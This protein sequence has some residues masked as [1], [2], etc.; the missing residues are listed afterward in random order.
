MVDNR[1]Q[2]DVPRSFL[3][4]PIGQSRVDVALQD[5]DEAGMSRTRQ[6]PMGW[7][8]LTALWIPELGLPILI[9]ALLPV[10]Y[11]LAPVFIWVGPIAGWIAAAMAVVALIVAVILHGWSLTGVTD[12][13]IPVSWA[14]REQVRSFARQVTTA[15][16][17]IHRPR[18]SPHW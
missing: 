13:P 2:G 16:Q 17:L 3:G 12:K 5:V 15:S 8:G 6:T 11:L 10:S 1:I 14:D 9:I 18:T 7:L 4:I